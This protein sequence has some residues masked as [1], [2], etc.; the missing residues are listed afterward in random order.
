L[1]IL[2]FDS[3]LKYILA[4]SII[5]FATFL[6]N[7]RISGKWSFQKP[8]CSVA[9]LQVSNFFLIFHRTENG[10]HISNLKIIYA[11][12]IELLSCK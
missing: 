3:L 7:L 4:S 1:K 6:K 2:L 9:H 10:K 11:A 8:T 5:I 12:K